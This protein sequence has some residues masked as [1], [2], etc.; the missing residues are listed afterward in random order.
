MPILYLVP[1]VH[2]S[3]EQPPG[4]LI[5]SGIGFV[6]QPL[7]IYVD[8]FL[9]GIVKKRPHCLKDTSNVWEKLNQV[10]MED[11]TWMCTYDMK[12]LYTNIPVQ[13][14]MEATMMKLKENQ[15]REPLKVKQ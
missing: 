15:A 8:S 13:E 4:R 9:Q 1:K 14:G 3:L 5:I 11:V 2:K 10:G 6:L 12:S 7:A